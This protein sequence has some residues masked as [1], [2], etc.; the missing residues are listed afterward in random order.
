MIL[1]KRSAPLLPEAG[2]D[3]LRV[4]VQSG[5]ISWPRALLG[6]RESQPDWISVHSPGFAKRFLRLILARCPANR[7]L[8]LSAQAA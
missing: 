5:H 8:I 7:A 3:S 1:A 6:T 2:E 4:P